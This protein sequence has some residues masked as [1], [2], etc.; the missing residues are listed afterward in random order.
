MEFWRIYRLVFAKRYLILGTM[1]VA[2]A[3]IFVG[4]SLQSRKRD[5]QAEAILQPQDNPLPEVVQRNADGSVS[6]GTGSGADTHATISDLIMIL[7]SSN[8]LYVKTA[9][10][11]RD[12]E[13]IRSVEVQ[14]ILDRNGYFAP[15]DT[16]IQ[17]QAKVLVE[18]GE[19]VAGQADKWISKNQE[20]EREK[21]VGLLA[22]GRDGSGEFAAAGV[23]LTEGQIA[24]QI[25]QNMTFET[26]QGPLS[27]DTAPQ[28]SNQIRVAA[29]FEREAEADLYVNLLCVEFLDFYTNERA[30]AVNAR[31]GLLKEKLNQANARLAAARKDEVVFRRS[32]GVQLTGQTDAAIV[33]GASLEARRNEAE[34]DLRGAES[35]VTTLQGVL[36]NTQATRTTALPP[37]ENPEVRALKTQVDDASIAFQAIQ[38]SNT[39]ENNDK[40]VTAKAR[41]DA[42]RQALQSAF[43]SPYTTTNVTTGIDT[44]QA[45]L[46]AA[47]V[48]RG[49]AAQ[50]LA[51]LEQ[52][53]AAQQAQLAN[54]PAA[55]ARLADL[56]RE[57]AISEQNVR[58]L[59]TTLNHESTGQI[60]HGRAGTIS[61]LS[62]AHAI[63][64]TSG[65]AAQRGKLIAYGMV[66]ALIF[67]IALVVGMDALDNSI[68]TA[69]DVEK[70]TGLPVAGIIPAHLPDPLRSPRVAL[71]EPMSPAAEA[72]RLLRTD[73]LFTSA[74]KPF[75]S[76][77]GAT[78]KPGQGS[79]TTL[80]NLA[81]VLAQ[82][83]KRVILVD[84]DLRQPKLH[85]IF[86][87]QN[88]N[89]L[90][91]VLGER[92]TLEEALT[93]TDVENLTLLP[94]GPLVLNPSEIL[95]SPRMHA[96]H[97]QLKQ[98]ADYVL[99]DTPSAIAF[100]DTALLSSFVDATLLVIRAN[101]VPRGT[102]E[103][104]RATLN[105]ARANL[106][107]VVLNGVAPED[108]DSVHYHA[109]YYPVLPSMP[110]D[111]RGSYGS[112]DGPKF[113]PSGGSNGTPDRDRAPRE[114]EGDAIALPGAGSLRGESGP[115]AGKPSESRKRAATTYTRD[116]NEQYF[117]VAGNAVPGVAARR[118]PQALQARVFLVVAAAGMAL[119]ALVLL[120]SN[121]TAVK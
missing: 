67:G 79:T 59:E 61:I 30:T 74:D 96:L 97:D 69:S 90:T 72:Y 94:G 77:L 34:A 28:I 64:Q 103:H 50:R 40:Y 84:A 46:N 109:S 23:K 9:A 27:T 37:S 58:D 106:I 107:G 22:R 83:G 71:L 82:A 88:D 101:N 31:I 73:L 1:V 65:I 100:S 42:A 8:D 85:R 13:G 89:G 110:V 51:V 26:V 36:Q 6:G 2:A 112:S 120:L 81:I 10:L 118:R 105:K 93:P 15:L 62:Q 49:S 7:R 92:C 41:F 32:T 66:L 99:F 57:I 52:Q 18:K 80:T 48:Q 3:V 21:I 60:E 44:L 115:A 108:V 53:F 78:A 117:S 17:G 70:L 47:E 91:A 39:G 63:P 4:T 20:A 121:G 55:Q 56:H 104:V 98:R 25:R 5:Y 19:L 54:L 76:L 95:G 116:A 24:D 87:T 86:G 75:Q 38:K 119:G 12:D 16:L 45:Q 113:L 102:E 35:A 29:K 114:E 43:A 111:E 33:Q 68:R 14:R 11:L